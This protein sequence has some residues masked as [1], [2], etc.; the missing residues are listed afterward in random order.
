M[1]VLVAEEGALAFKFI[2]TSRGVSHVV[3]LGKA[4]VVGCWRLLKL[5]FA[6]EGNRSL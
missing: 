3:H 1:F 5:Y 2:E 6:K 4:S